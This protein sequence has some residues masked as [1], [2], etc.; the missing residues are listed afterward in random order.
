MH[1]FELQNLSLDSLK[2]TELAGFYPGTVPM[3]RQYQV[4]DFCLSDKGW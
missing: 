1:T 4:T 2:I 3:P